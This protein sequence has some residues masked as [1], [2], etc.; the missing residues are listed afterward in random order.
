M[1]CDEHIWLYSKI[2][3]WFDTL[4]LILSD[5]TVI[6]LHRNHHASTALLVLIQYIGRDV[7]TSISDIPVFL[8]SIVHVFMY[9]YY[10][11]PPVFLYMKK[12]IT[13]IQILQHIIA[14]FIIIYTT[15]IVMLGNQQCD[16]GIISNFISL[17][18]YTMYLVQ[19]WNFYITSYSKTM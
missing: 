4:F 19:F 11:N 6:S 14:L 2:Y 16:T 3:E 12:F 7:R 13:R 15:I 17:L 10:L 18:S 9:L 1:T 8:N 5:K